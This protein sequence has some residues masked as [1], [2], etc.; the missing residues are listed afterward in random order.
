M[1]YNPRAKL[2]PKQVQN[3]KPAQNNRFERNEH[4]RYTAA[5]QRR[6]KRHGEFS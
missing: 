6:I 2:D 4:R 1:R 3:R 5:I